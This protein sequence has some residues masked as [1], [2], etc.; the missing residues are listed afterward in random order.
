M[1]YLPA[2]GHPHYPHYMRCV[3]KNFIFGPG[4]PGSRADRHNSTVGPFGSLLRAVDASGEFGWG[5]GPVCAA[6]AAWVLGGATDAACSG[7]P[8]FPGRA[9][10]ARDSSHAAHAVRTT[11]PRERS[12]ATAAARRRARRAGGNSTPTIDRL[13]SEGTM[14]SIVTRCAT[15]CQGEREPGM[16][17]SSLDRPRSGPQARTVENER[18]TGITHHGGGSKNQKDVTLCYQLAGTTH[19]EYGVHRSRLPFVALTLPI[20][21]SLH[22]DLS[23]RGRTVDSRTVDKR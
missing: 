21:S 13:L 9:V 2:S 16:A 7:C 10:A 23:D 17:R 12:S 14:S 19:R 20:L 15:S 18:W 22:Q 4:R 6:G 8:G 1:T 11:H 5:D 3:V